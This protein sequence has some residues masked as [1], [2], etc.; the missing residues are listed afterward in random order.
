L[1][2]GTASTCQQMSNA[3][4]TLIDRRWLGY[5]GAAFIL[6]KAYGRP[7]SMSVPYSG[8]YPHFTGSTLFGLGKSDMAQVVLCWDRACGSIGDVRASEQ[9]SYSGCL[10][11][12]RLID[13]LVMCP[14]LAYPT[15]SM[16]AH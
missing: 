1:P 8:T 14:P 10:P 15:P 11:M 5:F 13:V 16:I 7:K 3:I 12:V 2:M 6:S 4:K 9:S